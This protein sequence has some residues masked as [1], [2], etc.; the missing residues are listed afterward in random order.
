MRADEFLLTPDELR[1]KRRRRRL[2]IGGI[3]G[4]LILL[5][6]CAVAAR[7]T[8]HAI[9]GWQARRH[10]AKA[11]ALIDKQEWSS[12]RDEAVAAYQLR[13]TEP[14]ATRAVARLLSRT[15]QAQALDFW[16]ELAKIQPLTHDDLRDVAA[17][18]LN[19]G[20]AFRAE[21]AIRQLMAHD[22]APA[23]L[24][25]D[26]QLASQAGSSTSVRVDCEKVLVNPSATRKEQLQA[27][28]LE[29][30][31]SATASKEQVA[32]TWR[33]IEALADGADA[34]SLDALTVLAQ[35]A[36]AIPN[37]NTNSA[38]D[39]AI[40]PDSQVSHSA[41]SPHA[42]S[43]ALE[44]H[45]LSEVSHRL[46]A[47]DLL[48]RAGEAQRDEIIGRALSHFKN[49]DSNDLGALL[50]WLNSKHEYQRLVDSFPV[51]Q[52]SKGRE[53]FLQY[54]NALGALGRWAEMK[55][56]L[57]SDR[58]P[59]EPFLQRMYVARCNAQL[60]EKAA[61]ENNW[62]RAIEAAAG[63]PQKLVQVGDFAARNGLLDV[64][65]S[66]FTRAT[67]QA[68]K[69]RPVWQARLHAA[70]LSRNTAKVHSVLAEMLH[71]WPEDT[72]I[73]NDEAY[74]RLLVMPTKPGGTSS[75]SSNGARSLE[76]ADP[77]EV[78]QIE[79]LAERPCMK[80]RPVSRIAPFLPWRTCV[81]ATR[82]VLSA[83]MESKSRLT[84]SRLRPSWCG[85]PPSPLTAA[86]RK[87]PH[88]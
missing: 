23:D 54:L 74:T 26:A 73:Q 79:E 53:A 43:H 24:L 71:I 15:G 9:K 58:F 32:A 38:P 8:R 39:S 28:L 61:A 64:A 17:I 34:L 41:F 12:A 36:L 27:A 67:T 84:C 68:P 76:A 35:R 22:P 6:L 48:E 14:Q 75:V 65:D 11:F 47:L 3:L 51:E 85:L 42:I 40:P 4:L 82:I 7:P 62:L 13:S 19:T 20:Q 63:D 70:Q 2:I 10:A 29:M 18:A 86:P 49:G 21:A 83:P 77:G 33:R 52:V 45:P 87:L 78:Q 50:R 81:P 88:Y 44:N 57:Q 46:I 60:G 55:E 1:L 59:L 37:Q 56:L 31:V 80:S 30:R 16:N 69:L 25:L 5:V 66:A 72:S